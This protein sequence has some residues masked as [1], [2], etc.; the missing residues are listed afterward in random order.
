[1]KCPCHAYTVN[2]SL[3][4]D[5]SIFVNILRNRYNWIVVINKFCAKREKKIVCSTCACNRLKPREYPLKILHSKQTH[6]TLTCV[7]TVVRDST[8]LKLKLKR[9]SSVLC[10]YGRCPAIH[11]TR[12]LQN[13]KSST[14]CP[15]VR[16]SVMNFE[17]LWIVLVIQ[18]YNV[19][20]F[21][22]F[23]ITILGSNSRMLLSSLLYLSNCFPQNNENVDKL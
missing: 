6:K 7:Y 21:I 23:F 13:M 2:N 3:S 14:I 9:I 19:N 5:L 10:L 18:F 20:F 16:W 11:P 22:L 1:M 12:P 8:A 17:I 15:T 4:T